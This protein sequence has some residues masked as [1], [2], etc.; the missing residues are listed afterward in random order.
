V[1]HRAEF[2][3][4][5]GHIGLDGG[6]LHR[7]RPQSLEVLKRESKRGELT[8]LRQQI[9]K[10]FRCDFELARRMGYWLEIAGRARRI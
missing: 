2:D 10:A 6:H 5:I 3:G 7:A 9:E 8:V 4:R 1:R